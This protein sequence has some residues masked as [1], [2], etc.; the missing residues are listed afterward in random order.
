MRDRFIFAAYFGPQ[1]LGFPE[2]D[3]A[4]GCC[5]HPVPAPKLGTAKGPQI[6]WPFFVGCSSLDSECQQQVSRLTAET[7]VAGVDEYHAAR[8]HGTGAVQ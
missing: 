3:R 6:L 8:D 5:I 2:G 7:W 4:P 1:Q